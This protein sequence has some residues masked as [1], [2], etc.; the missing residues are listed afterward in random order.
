MEEVAEEVEEV[1]REVVPLQ[2]VE[3]VLLEVG[4]VGEAHL[5]C[6]RL[7]RVLPPEVVEVV[8]HRWRRP[9]QREQ[10][11]QRVGVVEATE[12]AAVDLVFVG[13]VALQQQRASSPLR[14]LQAMF[15]SRPLFKLSVSRDL[16]LVVWGLQSTSSS[17]ASQPTFRGT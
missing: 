17:I 5:P 9:Q 16:V 15:K 11:A 1:D 12:E 2:H 14:R 13:E 7:E 3:E 6:R 8:H 4:L 10:R